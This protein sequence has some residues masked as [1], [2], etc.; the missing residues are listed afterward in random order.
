M[1]KRNEL[2][3]MFREMGLT[4]LEA[5]IYSW[6]LENR[7]S[8]GY[9]I[10]M[11]IG[12]PVANTYKALKSL[13]RKGA[14]ISDNTLNKLY[15]DSVPVEQFL[16]KIENE[17]NRKRKKIINEVAKLDVTHEPI[18]IY[19]LQSGE[20]VFEKAIK[21]IN[22]AEHSLLIDCF[23]VPLQK[24]EKQILCRKTDKIEIF[25]KHYA[26]ENLE[27]V[28][29]IKK[30]E[31]DIVLEEL[32]GQWLIIVKDAVETLIAFFDKTGEEMMHS[33][34]I[35]DSFLSLIHFSGSIIECTLS[36]IL[37]KVYSEEDNQIEKIKDVVRSYQSIY[38]Y[39][40]VAEKNIFRRNNL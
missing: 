17:F 26:D 24:I 40:N 16:N 2:N 27:G 28:R 33:V 19:E 18:G 32:Q 30:T 20:L 39:F 10:A 14:V 1:E 11:K 9:K 36:E 8:T 7:R 23:P 25:L 34:W 6:L 15:Y 21:M 4:E 5:M 3:G 35:Q 13:E 31:S 38:S 37:E 22:S 29:Q 12:K